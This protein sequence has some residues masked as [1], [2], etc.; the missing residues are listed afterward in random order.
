MKLA[1]VKVGWVGWF[2]LACF[3]SACGV[4]QSHSTYAADTSIRP[5]STTSSELLI[6]G[7]IR[8]GD[9]T[10][11]TRMAD[12]LSKDTN[13]PMLGSPPNGVPFIFVKLDS[14][15]GDIIEALAIGR[16]VRRRF[17]LT[18]VVRN[19]ECDSACVFILAAGVERVGDG[20]V[21]LHRPAFDPAFFAGLSPTAAHDRY[22]SLVENLR[23]YYVD[24][25]GGSP[26]AFRIMMTTAST[27]IR[28]LSLSEML[29][30]GI[31]GED[32]A[33]A[34][35]NEAQSIQRYGRER[36]AII[37]A[38]LKD[39]REFNPCVAEAYRSYPER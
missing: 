25:M 38:C 7:E 14:P 20:K 13:C 10:R 30:L 23:Q 24:E 21:G 3:I 11:F 37:T 4:G 36:W 31:I 29:E 27:S 2:W 15:G 17:M 6:H 28:Y 35:Y 19:M 26:E 9:A 16:E 12:E 22:T 32:P 5:C 39:G 1:L 8:K 18:G 33:W 34:E